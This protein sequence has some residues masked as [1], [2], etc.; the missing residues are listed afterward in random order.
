MFVSAAVGQAIKGDIFGIL[1][2][3]DTVIYKLISYVYNIF[4]A[5]AQ[6]NLFGNDDYN[7]I[8]KNFYVILG[9]VMLFIL[10]YSLLKAVVDPDSFAKGEHSF[11]KIIQNVVVSLIIIAVLPTV[12]SVAFN[13]Q[14]TLLEKN[15][16]PKL[17]LGSSYDEGEASNAGVTLSYVVFS[18]F[19][20]PNDYWCTQQGTEL[21]AVDGDLNL[22]DCADLIASNGTLFFTNGE[23]LKATATKF[24]EGIDKYSITSFSDF[25]ESVADGR[26]TYNL[27][28]STIAGLFVLYVL[29]N[30]CFDLGIRVVKLAFFQIIAPIPVVCRILPGGKMK[31]VFS[32]WMK[33]TISTFLESFIRIAVMA[34]GVFIILLVNKKF[35]ELALPNLTWGQKA[36]AKALIIMGVIVFIKQAPKL[37]C[38]MFHIDSGNMKLGIADRLAQGGA[39]TAMAAATGAGGMMARNAVKAGKNIKKAEG[40]SG[41]VGAIA[42]GAGSIVA[43]AGSG[44]FRSGYGARNA[45]SFKD[46]RGAASSGIK[47]ATEAGSRRDAYRASHRGDSAIETMGNVLYGHAQDNAARAAAWLG[48]DASYDAFKQEKDFYNSIVAIDDNSDSV[49]ADLLTRDAFSNNEALMAA[50]SGGNYNMSLLAMK[51]QMQ[52]LSN[53]TYESF[54]GRTVKDFKGAEIVI[55]DENKFA[56][57]LASMDVQL[58]EAERNAKKF[59]KSQGYAG[60]AGIRRLEQLGVELKAGEMQRMAKLKSDRDNVTNILAENQAAMAGLYSNDSMANANRIMEINDGEVAGITGAYNQMDELVT[61]LKNRTIEIN[62]EMERLNRERARRGGNNS[63]G[64]S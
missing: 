1:L 56:S 29:V 60:E 34:F 42:R 3:I 47:A 7:G 50:A 30:F 6:I 43:G 48:L 12:F 17:I 9:L 20:H 16:I 35:A 38:D 2:Y 39:F 33:K 21:V 27:I 13:I 54:R 45:K 14:N 25:G 4:N 36:I 46:M 52:Q 53:A 40:F 23:S 55:D 26:I 18:G 10:A 24:H 51:K 59:I 64:N 37:I 31:D 22:S 57:Y 15:T 19:F 49:A 62:S 63:N 5:L 58:N 44:L 8:V 61:N 32:D 41:K 11:P 28:V